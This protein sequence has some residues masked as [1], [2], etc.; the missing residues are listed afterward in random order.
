VLALVATVLAASCG[1]TNP[2]P[3]PSRS[4]PV[5][6]T[7]APTATASNATPAPS[8]HL[9]VVECGRL[10]VNVCSEAIGVA[11]KALPAEWGI[12]FGIAADDACPPRAAC[13]RLHPFQAIVV[14][15]PAASASSKPQ[16]FDVFGTTGPERADR[17]TEALPEHIVA[18]VSKASR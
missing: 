18:L 15:I 5:L 16:A 1:S 11:R 4:L 13:D 10:G 8:E 7:P 9:T 12:P 2:P 3:S 14:F 17:W 6:V